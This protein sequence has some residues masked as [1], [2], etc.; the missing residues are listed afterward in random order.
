MFSPNKINIF[1]KNHFMIRKIVGRET[2]RALYFR[3]IFIIP[4]SRHRSV[5]FL[6]REDSRPMAVRSFKM[7]HQQIT[8]G[9][10]H[11]PRE[12]DSLNTGNCEIQKIDLTDTY[13]CSST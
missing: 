1:N 6:I 9:A 7:G 13:Y 5:L 3:N 8:L 4:F 10:V 12:A 11:H 2:K